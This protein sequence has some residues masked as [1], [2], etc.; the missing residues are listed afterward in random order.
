M[1]ETITPLRLFNKHQNKSPI[2][3]IIPALTL[4]N[5]SQAFAPFGANGE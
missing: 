1:G 2:F 3:N 5:G 4:C